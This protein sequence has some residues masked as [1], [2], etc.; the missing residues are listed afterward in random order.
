MQT[1]LEFV[2]CFKPVNA[3]TRLED[4]ATRR[5][6]SIVFFVEQVAGKRRHAPAVAVHTEAH[7]DQIDWLTLTSAYS[8][9]VFEATYQAELVSGFTLQPDLQYVMR[10]GGGVA[11]ERGRRLRNATVLGL[12]A[13]INY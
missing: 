7:V 10:P 12:R 1:S 4:E 5:K 9:T 8:E 6:F 11:D 3:W 2:A 13:T